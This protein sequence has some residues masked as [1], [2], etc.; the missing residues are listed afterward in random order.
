[1]IFVIPIKYDISLACKP[2]VHRGGVVGGIVPK[3]SKDII[4]QMV[5]AG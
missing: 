4:Q 2:Q 5:V 1:M 3:I